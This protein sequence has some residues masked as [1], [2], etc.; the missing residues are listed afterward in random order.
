MAT[1]RI[2]DKERFPKED[3]TWWCKPC[4]ETSMIHC[5]E[6]EVCGYMKIIPCAALRQESNRK[7]KR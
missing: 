7:G 6:V 4:R 5:A 3:E 1:K 2:T